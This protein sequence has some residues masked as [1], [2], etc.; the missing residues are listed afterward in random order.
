PVALV[1]IEPGTHT[2]RKHSQPVS[3]L[4]F[5]PDGRGLAVGYFNYLIDILDT[6][7]GDCLQPLAGHDGLVHGLAFSPDGSRLAST[8][9]D[10]SVRIWDPATG[11]EVLRLA[12]HTDWCQGLAFSPNGQLLASASKDGTIRLWDATL[13]TGN[14]RHEL[15]TFR[16]HTHRVEALAISP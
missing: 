4:V 7:T 12:G 2:L 1:I 11:Q 6:R 15:V 9:T 8:S 5:S 13:P 3:G 16:K 14:E 10:R